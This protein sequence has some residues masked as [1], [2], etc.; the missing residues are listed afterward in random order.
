M[1]ATLAKLLEVQGQT[2]T[3]ALADGRRIDECCL[4]ALP[5]QLRTLFWVSSGDEDIVVSP[6]EI[7]AVWELVSSRV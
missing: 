5:L 1:D 4:A 6:A 7:T 2:V 3:I